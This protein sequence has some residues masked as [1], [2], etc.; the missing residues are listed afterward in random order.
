[1][2]GTSKAAFSQGIANRVQDAAIEWLDG[3]TRSEGEK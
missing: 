2:Q 1:M 3:K